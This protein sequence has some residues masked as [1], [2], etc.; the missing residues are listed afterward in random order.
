M[1][2]PRNSVIQKIAPSYVHCNVLN[3]NLVINDLQVFHDNVLE[4]MSEC[5]HSRR[6]HYNDGA[7]HDCSPYEALR[8]KKKFENFGK[9]LTTVEHHKSRIQ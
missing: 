1:L 3:L 7:P 2:L 5:S 8:L 9:V 6:I 4:T